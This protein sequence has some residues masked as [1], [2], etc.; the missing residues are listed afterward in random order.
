MTI[1]EYEEIKNMTYREYCKY[2]QDKYGM[3]KC[4]FFTKSFNKNPKVTRTKEGLICHHIYEDKAIMLSTPA[5]AKKNPFKYQLRENLVYCDYLEH[6]YLHILICE[7]PAKNKNR[8]EEVG[9]GGVVNY[10]A[11]E[12]NDV[13]SGWKTAQPWRQMCHSKII[14]DKDLYLKLLQRFINI[15]NMSYFMVKLLLCRSFNEQFGGWS[16]KN[17]KMIYSEIINLKAG[18]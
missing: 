7:Y 3:A 8:N 5:Y 12:L 1:A 17:N 13:Y 18:N 4:D 15:N 2:L 11:P 9:V 6:L 10:I 16:S 14:N